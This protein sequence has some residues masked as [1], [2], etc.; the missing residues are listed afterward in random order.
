MTE[1]FN[2]DQ[3]GILLRMVSILTVHSKESR[4]AKYS[5]EIFRSDLA[6]VQSGYILRCAQFLFCFAMGRLISKTAEHASLV[7]LCL[8]NSQNH[9]IKQ[10]QA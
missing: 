1:K 6:D 9:I 2:L 8:F 3:P 5:P 10:M 7:S 4:E